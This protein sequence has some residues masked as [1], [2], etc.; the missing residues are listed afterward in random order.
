MVDPVRDKIVVK[1]LSIDYG[2]VPALKDMNFS[3][4][5][6]EILG[7]IGDFTTIYVDQVALPAYGSIHMPV[8]M[9]ATR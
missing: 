7:V 3:V 1:D 6:K 5:D 8:F 2:G 4:K 9:L